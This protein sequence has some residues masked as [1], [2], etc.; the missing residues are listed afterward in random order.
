MQPPSKM[1]LE[2]YADS[3]ESLNQDRP[4]LNPVGLTH[5]HRQDEWLIYIKLNQMHTRSSALLDHDD[6]VT[7]HLL[8]ETAL[9]DSQ[10]YEILSFEEI[11]NL[12]KQLS[13][14]SNRIEATKRKLVLEIKLRDAALSLDRL[15]SVNG[16]ESIGGGAGT[17]PRKHRRSM[18]GSRGSNSEMLS[19][20]DHEMT[21]STRKCDDLAQELWRLEKRAQEVQRRLLEHTAGILQMTHNGFPK[22]RSLPS[23]DS[24]P[25]HS[26]G[27]DISPYL[28]GAQDFDDRSFYQTL[29]AMLDIRGGERNI[30]S[31]RSTQEFEQ[32]TQFILN[33]ERRLEDFNKRLRDSITQTNQRTKDPP[34]P[35]TRLSDNNEDPAAA[36]QEQ[37]NYL[38]KGF[39]MIQEDQN[40]ALQSAKRSVYKTEERLEDLN[41]QIH[42]MI[43]RGNKDQNMQYPLPPEMSGHNS[44]AQIFYLEEGLDKLEQTLQR[45][46]DKI[47]ALSSKSTVHD[48]KA[49]QF[50]T[51]CLGLWDIILAGEKGSGQRGQGQLTGGSNESIESQS[52]N[53]TFSLP[54]FS[55]KVQSLCTRFTEL[56]EQKDIL[57]TQVQQQRSLNSRSDAEKDARLADLTAEL[58]EVKRSLEDKNGEL[59]S[60][61][62]E[63][64]QLEVALGAARQDVAFREKQKGINESALVAEQNARREAEEHLFADLQ[65]KQDEIAKLEADLQEFK[66]DSGITHAEMLG[67]LGESEA[68]IR[69]L[70]SQLDSHSREMENRQASENLLRESVSQK[71]SE[72]E[73]TQKEMQNLEA[74]MVRLRTELTVAKAELDGAYG[75]RAQR[76]AEVASN[77]ALQ[78][79]LDDLNGKN[80]ILA[81]DLATLKA[82]HK[83]IGDENDAMAER[84]QVLRRELSE[85]IAEYEVMTK[86]SIEFEKEREQLESAL[87]RLR[88]RC[89]SLETE[90]SD[91]KVCWLGVKSP[92]SSGGKDGNAPGTTSTT[93]LKN[94][95]RKIMKETR[96]ELMKNLK[97]SQMLFIEFS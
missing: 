86:L 61:K 91:E 90:L 26:N 16:R 3:L 58:D 17:S 11:D 23:P 21:T 6:P 36:L 50:E 44:V 37:L 79:E 20:A 41:T 70:T 59:Q 31:S 71:S 39:E 29:D 84:I 5:V 32:Q 53:S 13:F 30:E 81:S 77:P 83:N 7:M 54:D 8:M 9:G 73:K 72:L 68:H 33:T 10:Q 27:N 51:V 40:N 46:N 52:T 78:K 96:A 60:S 89:E 75:T 14:L 67:K 76:A 35:P 69:S 38:E 64:A 97:V 49:Q 80:A 15:H 2:E 55:A 18:L 45:L 92:G 24:V 12:K 34:V 25:D 85:T 65:T 94:E 19:Q 74:E 93:I 47:D 87:D 43:I 66:D 57:T 22:D 82:Q 56:Q 42:G 88:D 62:G 63:L 1:L 95:F 4:R 28:N 48:E